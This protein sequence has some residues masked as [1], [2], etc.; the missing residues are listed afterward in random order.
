MK[1]F[2]LL[3]TILFLSALLAIGLKKNN[4]KIPT[5]KN[6]PNKPNITSQIEVGER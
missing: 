1:S 6:N 5:Q 3:Q 4:I 2:F